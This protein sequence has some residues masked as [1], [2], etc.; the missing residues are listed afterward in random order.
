MKI[1]IQ[2]YLNRTIKLSGT[3][4]IDEAIITGKRR[5]NIGRIPRTQNW[6]LGIYSRRQNLTFMFLVP[7]RTRETII[8]IL[9]TC[10]ADGSEIFTD[11]FATY[12]NTRANPPTSA[13]QLALPNKRL[14]HRWV[15]HS[16]HYVHPNDPRIHIN[17]MENL[18]KIMRKHV[19]RNLRLS[20]IQNYIDNFLFSRYTTKIERYNILLMLIHE[21]EINNLLNVDKPFD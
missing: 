7:N 13:I 11:M 1:T 20:S 21:N 2:Q 8:P 3:I 12:V 18:W 17:N 5:G 10:I 4:E 9:N 16:Q 19:K 14:T 15:N 6:L